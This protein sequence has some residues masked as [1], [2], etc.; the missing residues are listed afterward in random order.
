[1][2][3][4]RGDQ[5][6]RSRG[7][8]KPKPGIGVPNAKPSNLDVM[9][10]TQP[11]IVQEVLTKEVDLY[12]EYHREAPP[13]SVSYPGR[14]DPLTASLNGMWCVWK[15]HLSVMFR[16][17]L[18]TEGCTNSRLD[19]KFLIFPSTTGYV[20]FLYYFVFLY[21]TFL[22]YG[23]NFAQWINKYMIPAVL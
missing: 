2:S 10:P 22:D 21:T 20:F 17:L 19:E 3:F 9:W 18:H 13:L 4:A 16:L 14:I 11:R 8:N 5:T 7:Q 6:T 12:R 23:G 15:S 1:M